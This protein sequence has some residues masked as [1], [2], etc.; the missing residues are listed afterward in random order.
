MQGD[1]DRA[2][3]GAVT[4]DGR[5]HRQVGGHEAGFVRREVGDRVDQ[6]REDGRHRL[7]RLAVEPDGVALPQ[8][9]EVRE[10]VVAQLDDDRGHARVAR[11]VVD[12]GDP[13]RVAQAEVQGLV[14]QV[15][16]HQAA[17]SA[18]SAP[19]ATHGNASTPSRMA[20]HS[21][22]EPNRYGS[23]AGSPVSA[24][25]AAMTARAASSSG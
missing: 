5:L 9:D 13:E 18:R 11:A 16:A 17:P 24:E 23:S 19:S 12:A 2:A 1:V 22:S 15:Q 20:A 3:G 4:P 25:V 6:Q 7:G 10:P 14:G 21:P 8:P